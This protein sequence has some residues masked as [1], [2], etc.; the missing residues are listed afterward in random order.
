MFEL[1]ERFIKFTKYNESF[2]LDTQGNSKI[3]IIRFQNIQEM[4]EFEELADKFCT[5][6][7]YSNGLKNI[8]SYYIRVATRGKTIFFYTGIKEYYRNC[9]IIDY[10]QFIELYAKP[11]EN[12]LL[13]L[14]VE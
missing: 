11:K 14:I 2:N 6:F 4:K 10:M 8:N 7:G 12:K 9:N 5:S 13:S 3:N 1:D